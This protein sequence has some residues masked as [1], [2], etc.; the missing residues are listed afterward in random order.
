M[1]RAHAFW[2]GSD[3]FVLA[4]VRIRASGPSSRSRPIRLIMEM[5]LGTKIV[6]K[7]LLSSGD[8]LIFVWRTW[9][10]GKTSF[11]V[12]KG[13]PSKVLGSLPCSSDKNWCISELRS[14][15]H[16]DTF[17]VS[18]SIS[19]ISWIALA[20]LEGPDVRMH[21]WASTKVSEPL[22]KATQPDFFAR[23]FICFF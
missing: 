20:R 23:H 13:N 15:I 17:L 4:Q 2:R 12:G 21:T 8:T 5:N 22:Q 7:V 1:I 19:M 16:T 10:D 18:K 6:W 14:T 9:I 3:T 11:V